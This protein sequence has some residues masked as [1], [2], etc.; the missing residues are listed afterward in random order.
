[1]A[2]DRDIRDDDAQSILNAIHMIK[3]VGSVSS[4]LSE[5]ADWINREHVKR[6]VHQKLQEALN[7]CFSIQA[8]GK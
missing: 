8:E 5:P 3:G 1:M 7:S 2:F 6:E 4:I